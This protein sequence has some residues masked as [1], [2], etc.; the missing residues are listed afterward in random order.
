MSDT[1][2][3]LLTQTTS[4]SSTLRSLVQA[5]YDEGYRDGGLAMRDHIMQAANAPISLRAVETPSAS[6]AHIALETASA[7]LSASSAA[8]AASSAVSSDNWTRYA[9]NRPAPVVH[10]APSPQESRIATRAPR[11]LVRAAVAEALAASPGLA[12]TDI[13]DRVVTQHPEVARKS[14]GNQLRQFEGDLYRREGKYKWF[15]MGE[16]QKETASPALPA[17]LADLLGPVKGGEAQ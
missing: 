1:L 14:V 7:N 9:F 12:I 16:P 13:E 4:L 3:S 10:R 8:A 15:L 2:Q 5:A 11:G 6:V 17:D